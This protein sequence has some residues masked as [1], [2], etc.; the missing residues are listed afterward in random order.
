MF[1]SNLV[2]N[3]INSQ[4]EH[5]N[6]FECVLIFSLPITCANQS[7]ESRRSKLSKLPI[8]NLGILPTVT[9]GQARQT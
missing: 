3:R 5:K 6:F 2:D 4:L 7:N 8:N 9:G 1:N